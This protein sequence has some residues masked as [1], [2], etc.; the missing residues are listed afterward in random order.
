MNFDNW[1]N[2]SISHINFQL[3]FICALSPFYK[4]IIIATDFFV[5]IFQ[6][7]FTRPILMDF[8]ITHTLLLLFF[9][10]I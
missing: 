10:K 7:L 9:F 4:K 2:L 8:R 1:E 5:K 3:S 6:I